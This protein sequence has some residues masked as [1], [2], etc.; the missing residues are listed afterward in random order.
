M[1]G[2]QACIP[3]EPHHAVELGLVEIARLIDEP[4]FTLKVRACASCGQRFLWAYTEIIDWDRGEDH[5]CWSVMPISG[6]EAEA[7]IAVG[8]AIDLDV[9]QQMGRTR[10]FL[11]DDEQR[12]DYRFGVFVGEHS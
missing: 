11:R 10:R 4:H 12:F 5:E 8:G 9:V 3:E 1:Y 6:D 2:C 7:F